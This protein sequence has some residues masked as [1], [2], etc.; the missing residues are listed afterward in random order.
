VSASR[1]LPVVALAGTGRQRGEAHG[2][3]LRELV[4]EAVDRWC[5]NV[6]G[7]APLDA[8]AYLTELVDNSGFRRAIN[9]YAPDLAAEVAGIAAGAG[10]DERLLSATT[11]RYPPG[12]RLGLPAMASKASNAPSSRRTNAMAAGPSTV[13]SPC[14]TAASR[15][16]RRSAA[17]SCCLR[18]TAIHTFSQPL[19]IA[20]AELSDV[21][22]GD[23]SQRS[24]AGVNSAARRHMILATNPTVGCRLG[25]LNETA[26]RLATLTGLAQHPDYLVACHISSISVRDR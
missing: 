19:P 20:Q 23:L 10:A 25:T 1:R 21:A 16:R 15:Q 8:E 17:C 22:R 9:R 14:S 12:R 13:S 4:L 7:R 26:H 2:E 3:S 11:L 24:G 18:L 5:A 6:L